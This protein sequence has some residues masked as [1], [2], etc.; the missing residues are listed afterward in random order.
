MKVNDKF[1][2]SKNI[3]AIPLIYKLT[4]SMETGWKN[5]NIYSKMPMSFFH[6]KGS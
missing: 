3:T 6:M 2:K 4:N 1:S 5:K